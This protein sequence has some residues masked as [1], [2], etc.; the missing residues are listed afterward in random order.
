MA[1]RIDIHIPGPFC[2]ER[3]RGVRRGSHTAFVDTPD[4]AD[5]KAHAKACAHRVMAGRAPLDGP[6]QLAVC[7]VCTPPASTP[8]RPTKGNP[9]PWAPWKKPDKDNLHKILQDA[10][11][12]LVWHDD[13]RLVDG[14]SGKIWDWADHDHETHQGVHLTVEPLRPTYADVWRAHIHHHTMP[15]PEPPAPYATCRACGTQCSTLQALGDGWHAHRV[16]GWACPTCAVRLAL[17]P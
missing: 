4:R 13:A 8:K 14:P 9:W 2:S 1:D 10:L 15:A 16:L 6:L 12:E 3:K 11:N 5:W 17:T 7:W